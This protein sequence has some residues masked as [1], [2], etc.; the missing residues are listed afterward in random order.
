[1]QDDDKWMG[2]NALTIP[3]NLHHPVLLDGYK[4]ETGTSSEF[5]VFHNYH[6]IVS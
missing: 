6:Q 5:C 4:T 2:Q 3:F 1:M